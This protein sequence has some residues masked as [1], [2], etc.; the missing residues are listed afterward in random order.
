MIFPE[1]SRQHA[2]DALAPSGGFV[3]AQR[4]ILPLS[5]LLRQC[6]YSINQDVIMA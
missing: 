2:L 1:F 6:H 4:E 5:G 3:T